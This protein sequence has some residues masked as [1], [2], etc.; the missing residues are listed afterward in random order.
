LRCGI[1]AGGGDRT[2]WEVSRMRRNAAVRCR[3]TESVCDFAVGMTRGMQLVVRCVSG[4]IGTTSSEE[5]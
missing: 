1:S 2:E 5:E 4:W 3:P